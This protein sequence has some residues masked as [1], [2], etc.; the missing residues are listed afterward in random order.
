[1]L[2]YELFRQENLSSEKGV[3]YSMSCRYLMNSCQGVTQLEE[4]ASLTWRKLQRKI[5]LCLGINYRDTSIP[6]ARDQE[7]F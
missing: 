6:M 1:M 7:G 3:N 2:E 5:D 4:V